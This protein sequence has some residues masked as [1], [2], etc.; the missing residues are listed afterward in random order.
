M[1]KVMIFGATGGVWRQLSND[2]V[3]KGVSVHLVGRSGSDVAALAE[4]LGASFSHAAAL[5]TDSASASL[6]F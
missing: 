5:D 6:R 3:K 1:P 2:L 4:Q